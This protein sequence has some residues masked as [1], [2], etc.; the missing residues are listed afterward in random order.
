MSLIN[1][2]LKKAQQRQQTEGA[3][4]PADKLSAVPSPRPSPSAP[5]K[6]I[7]MVFAVSV[8]LVALIGLGGWQ[9]WRMVAA[10]SE[11]SVASVNETTPEVEKPAMV[12]EVPAEDRSASKEDPSASEEAQEEETAEA[13]RPERDREVEDYLRRASITAREA[14]ENSRV[15]INGRFY[16]LQEEVHFG[17][18]LRV[19][20]VDGGVVVFKD[21]HGAEYRHRL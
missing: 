13:P 21:R 18:S 3:P 17:D 6:A 12:T 16:G 10:D 11:E 5:G 14:G 20:E 8:L 19:V 15:I 1:D 2:A 7:L 9:V 4:P